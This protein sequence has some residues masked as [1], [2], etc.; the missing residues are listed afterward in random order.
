MVRSFAAANSSCCSKR[1]M[2]LPKATR[3]SSI[4]FDFVRFKTTIANLNPLG[5]AMRTACTPPNVPSLAETSRQFCK[6]GQGLATGFSGWSGTGKMK[7]TATRWVCIAVY[8]V[9]SR[10]TGSCGLIAQLVEQYTFNVRVP[11]SSPGGLTMY[12]SC[13][14]SCVPPCP[15]RLVWPRTSPF[16]G[17]NGGSNPPGDAIFPD[18]LRHTASDVAISSVIDQSVNSFV[19]G[20]SSW[21]DSLLRK[22]DNLAHSFPSMLLGGFIVLRVGSA[23][24]VFCFS[25]VYT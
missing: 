18:K 6:K 11:G 13:F 8:S 9:A 17:G 14:S 22:N 25:S 20:S 3:K 4:E 15:Y 16:H 2:N 24:K 21:S 19:V 12:P 10:V 23:T 7:L 1:A 5:L